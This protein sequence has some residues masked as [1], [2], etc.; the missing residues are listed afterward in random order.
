MGLDD[1]TSDSSDDSPTDDRD[2]RGGSNG[3]T[4]IDDSES[5]I[6]GIPSQKY[7][8]MSEEER[9]KAVRQTS[10]EDFAPGKKFNDDWSYKNFTVISCSCGNL[11]LITD[12]VTCSNCGAEYAAS[13]RAVVR[14]SD[15]DNTEQ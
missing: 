9:V 4:D 14:V 15:G 12:E 2:T 10:I 3:N 7:I 1:F 5:T 8:A 6:F 13:G 11:I